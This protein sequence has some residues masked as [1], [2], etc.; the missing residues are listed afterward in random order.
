MST[1]SRI[2]A[3]ALASRRSGAKS[4]GPKTRAGKARSSQNALKHG[5]RA[6]K[7]VVLPEEDAAE[8][9]HLEAALLAELAPVDARPGCRM[10]PRPA[11][12]SMRRHPRAERTLSCG[13]V[14]LR[15]G[16][17]PVHGVGARGRRS[18]RTAG[19]E[20]AS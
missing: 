15:W 17:H 6:A 16:A 1:D 3:R 11:P 7:Y 18:E 14:A 5:M 10:N 2:R 4:R 19:L 8:F 12:R 13:N 20:P 9:A